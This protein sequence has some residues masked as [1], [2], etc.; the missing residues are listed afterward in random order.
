[1]RNYWVQWAKYI[2][3][4]GMGSRDFALIYSHFLQSPLG[5]SL[6][7]PK[8]LEKLEEFSWSLWSSCGDPKTQV[9]F[10]NGQ[11]VICKLTCCLVS[12]EFDILGQNLKGIQTVNTFHITIVHK[13]H[14]NYISAHLAEISKYLEKNIKFKKEILMHIKT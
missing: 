11:P 3:G 8:T 13:N 12:S 9:C 6:N 7:F 2:Y 5:F 14:W 10:S 4:F 1:M